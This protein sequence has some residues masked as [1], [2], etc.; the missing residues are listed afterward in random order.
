MPAFSIILPVYKVEE[1]LDECIESILSQ[2]F[3]DFELIAVDDCSPDDSLAILRRHA[4]RDE[5][6]RVLQMERNAGVGP[7]RNAGLDQAT[8]EYVWFIDG[9]DWIEPGSLEAIADRARATDADIVLFGWERRYE[10]GRR[11]RG[12]E[13]HLFKSAP[14]AF[15]L[16]QYPELTFVLHVCW[17][18]VVRRNLIE[19]LGYHFEGGLGQDI[20]FTY[21][22]LAAAKKI[23][24]LDRICVGY[25]QRGTNA[26]KTPSDKHFDAFY[27]WERAW[28]LLQQHDLLVPP[29]RRY[30]FFRM[31]RHFVYIFNH[32]SRILNSSR[33]RFVITAREFYIRFRPEK[34]IRSPSR[35][36]RLQHA[37]IASGASTLLETRRRFLKFKGELRA[38]LFSP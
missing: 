31:I 29:V 33:K 19:R 1:W 4:E 18:K 24:I 38:K 37:M 35:S 32:P 12:G 16:A 10:G 5:R 3:T 22:V 6:L 17:N 14:E 11:T 28:S 13:Q 2:S 25:R 30:L 36:E 20:D 7:A 21:L 26:T 8:G 9:D 23:S 15:T 27:H 34:L